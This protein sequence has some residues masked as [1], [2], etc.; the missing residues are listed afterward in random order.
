MHV[1]AGAGGKR[2]VL[3]LSLSSPS[4]EKLTRNSYTTRGR[5][6]LLLP[7]NLQTPSATRKVRKGAL[8]AILDLR[9]SFS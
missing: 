5:S 9:A 4:R 2:R 3:R 1:S 8:N 7:V 6:I